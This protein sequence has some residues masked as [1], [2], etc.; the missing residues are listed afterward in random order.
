MCIDM[1][2]RQDERTRNSVLVNK[3]PCARRANAEEGKLSESAGMI[4]QQERRFQM[5]AASLKTLRLILT[6][7]ST[8]Y[9]PLRRVAKLLARFLLGELLS[10]FGTRRR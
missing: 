2:T 3:A 6:P 10:E 5:Y 1:L 8:R 7:T 4:L 9:N